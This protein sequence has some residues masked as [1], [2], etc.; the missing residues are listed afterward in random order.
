MINNNVEFKKVHLDGLNMTRHTQS[1][2]QHQEKG[3]TLFSV[4]PN[5]TEMKMEYRFKRPKS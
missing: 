5:T 3:W 1:I 2:R 4:T